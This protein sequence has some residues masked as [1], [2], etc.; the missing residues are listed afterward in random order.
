MLILLISKG[1]IERVAS[2]NYFAIDF[3]FSLAWVP[4]FRK[5]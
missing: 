3:L 2:L 4:F 5:L 1:L